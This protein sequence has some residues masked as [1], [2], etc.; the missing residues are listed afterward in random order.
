M[1]RN[2][3]LV[4]TVVA[5]RFLAYPCRP[6]PGVCHTHPIQSQSEESSL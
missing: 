3:R 4:G 2:F 6:D 5:V 1:V